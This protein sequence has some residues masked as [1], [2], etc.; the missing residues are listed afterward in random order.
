MKQLVLFGVWVCCSNPSGGTSPDYG[1]VPK[2]STVMGPGWTSAVV[3]GPKRNVNF[4]TTQHAAVDVAHLPACCCILTDTHETWTCSC[5]CVYMCVSKPVLTGP[6][7]S[8]RLIHGGPTDL[9]DPVLRPGW[10]GSHGRGSVLAEGL[11]TWRVPQQVRT[12]N[13][14]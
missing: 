5:S 4:G 8:C 6:V 11:R 10:S 14:P 9:S 7:L 12:S 3:T 13:V 1:L 2:L